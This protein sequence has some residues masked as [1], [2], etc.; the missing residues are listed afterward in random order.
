[1]PALFF[2]LT[3]AFCNCFVLQ[4]PHDRTEVICLNNGS[5]QL[6]RHMQ[7]IVWRLSMLDEA[8]K[9]CCGITLAQSHAL[10][11]IGNA[12]TMTL[13]DLAER[14]NLDKST[15]SRTISN[16]AAQ[17]LCERAVDPGDRRYV[18]IRL[19]AAGNEI[20]HKI[21]GDM[22]AYFDRIYSAIP[23]D[24]RSQIVE[25]AEILLEAIE[26]SGCCL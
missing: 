4:P 5:K 1:M 2:R 25:S 21:K 24:K 16:L 8:E 7:G 23:T 26:R 9:S 11:E 14:L 19:T 13:N 17:D 6:K 20:Y 22:D 12:G 3:I 18:A 10:V 15:M